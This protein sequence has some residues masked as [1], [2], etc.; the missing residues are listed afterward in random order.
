MN[1]EDKENNTVENNTDETN[2]KERST[3]IMNNNNDSE[4][5]GDKKYDLRHLS[6]EEYFEGD[7][8][9][10]FQ[11]QDTVL[12]IMDAAGLSDSH[13]FV[14]INSRYLIDE[15]RVAVIALV[16]RKNARL[17]EKLIIDVIAGNSS[18]D[19]ATDVVYN[20]GSDCDYH[21][22]LCDWNSKNKAPGL[23]MT[24][25]IMK[26]LINHFECHLYLFWISAD[27]LRDVD[28]TKK[29]IYTV[30]ESATK[31]P[32]SSDMPDRRGLEYAELR[33]YALEACGYSSSHDECDLK[34]DSYYEDA[35]TEWTEEGI[36]TE[37]N[38]NND[39]YTWLFT[40]R[41]ENI[42]DDDYSYVYDEEKGILTITDD[43][44]FQNFKNSLPEAKSRLAENYYSLARV[45]SWIDELLREKENEEEDE[46]HSEAD[47]SKNKL[48]P[49]EILGPAQRKDLPEFEPINLPSV[50]EFLGP[51][52]KEYFLK[53]ETIKK[54]IGIVNHQNEIQACHRK[55]LRRETGVTDD[56]MAYDFVE[57]SSVT[58]LG[59]NRQ[60]VIALFRD[61]RS[62]LIEKWSIDITSTAPLSDQF[63][64]ALYN[65]DDDCAIIIILYFE[66]PEISNEPDPVIKVENKAVWRTFYNVCSFTDKIYP[67]QVVTEYSG[68]EDEEIK[69]KID[70]F[71]YPISIDADKRKKIPS[72]TDFENN[73][74]NSY[75]GNFKETYKSDLITDT[76]SP[77]EKI[78]FSVWPNWTEKGLF[79]ELVAVYDC[80]ETNWLLKDKKDELA[81]RYPGC[82]VK[83]KMK[84]SIHYCI[85]IQLHNAPVSDFV[86]SPTRAKFNY[87]SEIREQVMAL[88]RHIEEIFQDY[89]TESE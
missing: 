27:A 63:F 88:I 49:M 23:W 5:K 32:N 80:P 47:D 59:D 75:Y 39:D 43:L 71:N 73:I 81:R 31:G 21:M 72:R 22:I 84:P 11:E 8:R 69:F 42:K 52:W 60:R 67:M 78:P 82:E 12:S 77:Y 25:N 74:W 70:F 18:F 46:D 10:H 87:A 14:Q 40:E 64:Y 62:G 30:M 34:F 89:A 48:S 35:Q 76:Y 3:K 6:F 50:L 9:K 19:Q 20:I 66:R 33:F 86:E 4:T 51:N 26:A 56:G 36:I 45:G 44:P 15:N 17:L 1:H 53:P 38:I 79:M 37:V 7:W 29:V 24:D 54:I 65:S 13:D 28:G 58:Q 41:I 57:I 2:K 61:I 85:E 83:V 16:R 55:C 68:I